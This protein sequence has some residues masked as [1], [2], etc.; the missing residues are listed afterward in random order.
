[1]Y[2]EGVCHGICENQ[3]PKPAGVKKEWMNSK[4][5]TQVWL[6]D[7]WKDKAQDIRQFPGT[8]YLEKE[9]L[10]AWGQPEEELVSHRKANL[11]KHQMTCWR[12]LDWDCGWQFRLHHYCSLFNPPFH[13]R[14]LKMYWRTLE[15]RCV[16]P[17]LSGT[18]LSLQD[19]APRQKL[20]IH[21]SRGGK[22]ERSWFGSVIHSTGIFSPHPLPVNIHKGPYLE[23]FWFSF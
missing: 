16:P 8:S 19:S 9:G 22:W 11:P 3:W 2:V 1:M 17:C 4:E 13:V 23:A 12:D 18:L 10:K 7:F 21:S 20:V 5:Y 15:V 14:T 6:L